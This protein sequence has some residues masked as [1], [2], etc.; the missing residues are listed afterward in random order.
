MSHSSHFVSLVPPQSFAALRN[1]EE[2]QE[3][4]KNYNQRNAAGSTAPTCVKARKRPY[5]KP[6]LA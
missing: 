3:N 4:P 6:S 2:P 5:A 1:R